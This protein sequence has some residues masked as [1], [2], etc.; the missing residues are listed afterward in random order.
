MLIRTLIAKLSC[1]NYSIVIDLSLLSV[2][3][4]TFTRL[5]IGIACTGLVSE[6]EVTAVVFTYP[7]SR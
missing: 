7:I 4:D 3:K 2:L 5:E 6:K 1:V